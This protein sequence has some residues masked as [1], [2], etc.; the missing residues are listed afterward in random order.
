MKKLDDNNNN[1]NNNNNNGL[2]TDP[3]DGSS[4]LKYINYKSK[5]NQI[6]SFTNYAI[7]T[8]VLLLK[9]QAGLTESKLK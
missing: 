2:L 6:K 1:N 9:V 5:M 3:L 8:K 7:Y 4:L